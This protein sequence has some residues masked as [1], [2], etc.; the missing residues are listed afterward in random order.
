MNTYYNITPKNVGWGWGYGFFSNY[1][2]CLEQLILHY[3][4]GSKDI[5]YINWSKTTWVEGFDPF[6]SQICESNVNP[7]DFWFDQLI[8]NLSDTIINCTNGA[9]PDII[10]HAKHYFDE[11]EQLKRQQEVDKLYIK[12][13][14]YLIDKINEI[15]DN[16]LSGHT[17][18][19]VMIRGS[20]YNQKTVNIDG[21]NLYGNHDISYYIEEI[22]KILDIHPEIDKLYLVSDEIDYINKLYDKFPSSYFIPNVFR[23]TDETMEYIF[24]VQHW[25]NVS[26]KRED[27]NKLLGEE[28]II[29][30]KLLGKCDYLFGR[31]SGVLLSGVLWNEK[32]KNIYII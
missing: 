28:T 16:E 11:P 12:P 7:F 15:Y 27:H 9:R 22:Q 6:E 13:K 17:V 19:G 29:Q 1:R 24:K 32:L 25:M 18:L 5:P 20:E 30:T 26:K 3:E 31:L 4:S 21:F 8:P 2:L 14:Q 10:H 23:R